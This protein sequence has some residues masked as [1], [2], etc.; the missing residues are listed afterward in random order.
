M[1]NIA[2]EAFQQFNLFSEVELPD[3][4]NLAALG[5]HVYNVNFNSDYSPPFVNTQPR[6]RQAEDI[7]EGEA[8]DIAEAAADLEEISESAIEGASS[9]FLWLA[10]I[11]W[12]TVFGKWFIYFYGVVEIGSLITKL[13]S[14]ISGLSF[15]DPKIIDAFTGLATDVLATFE[16][17]GAMIPG[18]CL[19]SSVL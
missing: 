5:E 17:K 1:N 14:S 13:N 10:V 8:E 7:S 6:R 15:D 11:N 12:I 9:A 19:I 2:A 18:G 3:M 4:D 16:T